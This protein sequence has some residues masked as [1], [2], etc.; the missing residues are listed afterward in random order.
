MAMEGGNSLLCSFTASRVSFI[1][2]DVSL[3]LKLEV[4]DYRVA[5]VRYMMLAVVVGSPPHELRINATVSTVT[6][7]VFVGASYGV[8]ALIAFTQRHRKPFL[9][10]SI[11]M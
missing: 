1:A 2:R 8:S 3:T 4:S 11:F 5:G 6:A 7:F 10:H 9:L